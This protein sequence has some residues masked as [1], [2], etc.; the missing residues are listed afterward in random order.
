MK[1]LLLFGLVAIALTS[2]LNEDPGSFQEQ[3]KEYALADFTELEMSD[4]LQ[5]TVLYGSNYSVKVEGDRRNIDDLEIRT[6]GTSLRMRFINDGRGYRQ[7]KTY[8]TVT[9]P[10]LKGASFSGA[11][12][13]SVSGFTA[14]E[15]M[16]IKLSGASK[17]DLAGSVKRFDAELS[18]ASELYAFTFESESALITASGASRVEVLATQEL[19]A[20]A[21]GA[22]KIR[23]RGNPQL[24]ANASG[25]SFIGAD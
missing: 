10:S 11:I 8:V 12:K 25:A 9:M 20:N 5:V 4:A 22:S 24:T 17:L 16:W 19:K 3:K 2:C 14:N 21:S 1:N 23:Y 18:G 6:V 7:Y 15:D 13:S